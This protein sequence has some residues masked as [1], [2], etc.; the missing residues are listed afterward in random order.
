MRRLKFKCTFKSDIVLSAQTATEGKQE[1]LDYI[2]GSNFLGI[3]ASKLYANLNQEECFNLL[4]SDKV[5]FGDA[6]ISYE[7]EKTL[8]MPSSY[9]MKKG[10][11]IGD[12]DVY[13]H[14][15]ILDTLRQELIDDGI[16]LK[17]VRSGYF[18]PKRNQTLKID[19]EFALKSA[20]NR[21][22]RSSAEGKMYGYEA[23][24]RST[25]WVFY[26]DCTEEKSINAIKNSLTGQKHI[27]RSKSA[28]YG[29]VNIE[30][31]AQEDK[32]G[33]QII[34]KG[35]LV[36]YAE[37]D[38][39]FVN[40]YGED[41][42]TPNVSHFNLPAK[43]TILWDESQVRT[44]RYS[45]WN[46]KRFNRDADRN[47]IERGSVFVIETTQEVNTNLLS[48]GIG[49]YRN[50]GLGNIL[51]NPEF[52]S[53]C[54]DAILQNPF[55]Q[56]KP[57]KYTIESYSNE[58]VNSSDFINWLG[59]SKSNENDDSNILDVIDCFRSKH[60]NIYKEISSSQWGAI[61]NIAMVSGDKKELLEQLFGLYPDP[62]LNEENKSAYLM[63]GGGYEDLWGQ[64]QRKIILKRAID[65]N[66]G[67]YKHLVVADSDICRC[68]EKLASQMQKSN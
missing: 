7:N 34:P 22:T 60:E 1:S 14:H 44:R 18:L 40:K 48:D 36:I 15:E 64:K 65:N 38:I 57:D 21:K 16:Q 35:K 49:I 11:K 17:Q 62:Y 26:V 19:K 31:I 12:G 66:F 53:N 29:L 46:N 63:H 20:Y 59:A 41:C 2:P 10:E 52:L 39:A 4:H 23:L 9:F 61:R 58:K 33:E 55:S 67:E 51:I 25:E 32:P 50:E 8:K 28:Q 6:H 54:K 3:A 45:P 47:V 37:S 27:G 43:S 24:K 68:V 30:F 13:I 42:L 56:L 5:Q